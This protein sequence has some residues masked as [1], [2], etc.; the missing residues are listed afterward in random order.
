MSDGRENFGAVRAF[1]RLSGGLEGMIEQGI[2]LDDLAQHLVHPDPNLDLTSLYQ[3]REIAE[4][5][6]FAP[7]GT[8]PDDDDPF[9]PRVIVP[10]ESKEPLIEPEVA[11]HWLV[12]QT[13]RAVRRE[14]G[15]IRLRSDQKPDHLGFAAI[16]IAQ[17]EEA[18]L[19]S[20]VYAEVTDN[21]FPIAPAII[22]EYAQNM[23]KRFFDQT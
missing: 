16:A 22:K 12:D 15:S 21:E 9:R 4:H 13:H 2:H 1:V 3:L 19:F 10:Q 14:D 17:G 20:D 18:R 11:A 6:G 5:M 7:D 23:V 8:H